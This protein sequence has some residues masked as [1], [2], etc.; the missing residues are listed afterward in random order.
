MKSSGISCLADICHRVNLGYKVLTYKRP[1]K[2]V[3]IF[4]N[5]SLYKK[6]LRIFVE[7][8]FLQT[9]KLISERKREV[10]VIRYVARSRERSSPDTFAFLS[11]RN[12]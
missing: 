4:C 5:V 8:N 6:N 10:R 3:P 1:A 11:L 9:M 2:P 7:E 12:A